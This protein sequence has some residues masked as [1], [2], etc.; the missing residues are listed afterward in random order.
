MSLARVHR[1]NRVRKEWVCGKCREEIPVGAGRLAFA[2]GFRGREQTRCLKPE[3]Y[4]RPSERES[5]LVADVYA[6]QE[7]VDFTTCETTEE[8]RETL[9]EII[10]ACEDVV[11]Q[12][13]D[14][15]MFDNNYDLQERAE[16]IEQAGEELS[17]W[18][19]DEEEPELLQWSNMEAD[20]REQASFEEAHEAWRISTREA[21][22]GLV[23]E[24]E[25][26]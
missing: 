5:S 2:V 13:Q 9:Q 22:E 10:D 18:D 21:L 3:C 16:M 25:L 12:Y 1:M 7:S 17:N 15:P 26:P 14:H 19:P 6:A 23:T 24:M 11:S 4:P 8:F 20:D